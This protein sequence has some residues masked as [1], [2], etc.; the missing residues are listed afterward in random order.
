MMNQSA[1]RPA[2]EIPAGLGAAADAALDAAQAVY[3]RLGRAMAVATAAAVRDILT[4]H[5]PDAPFDA[6]GVELVEGEDGALFPTGRYWT[7][8]GEERTFAETVG[9]GEAGSGIHGMSEWTVYLDD[10]TQDVWRPLCSRLPGRNG[11]PVWRL[12]L[13]RA[14]ALPLGE[15][16]VAHPLNT[17][18]P[19]AASRPA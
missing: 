2:Y 7:L 15:P 18:C 19:G 13:L 5:E 14:A 8:S 4:G 3:H 6:A 1:S 10:H 16:V 12:D 9:E 11:R 17:P